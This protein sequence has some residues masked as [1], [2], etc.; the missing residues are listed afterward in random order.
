MAVMRALLGSLLAFQVAVRAEES[1]ALEQKWGWSDLDSLKDQVKESVDANS[2]SLDDVKD[3]VKKRA[4]S[5]TDGIAG[6]KQA[7]KEYADALQDSSFAKAVAAT[8]ICERLP[9]AEE[10]S[11]PEIEEEAPE[12]MGELSEDPGEDPEAC[13]AAADQV[14]AEQ[15]KSQLKEGETGGVV[16]KFMKLV[17]Q[18]SSASLC[19]GKS[20]VGDWLKEN[21]G[22]RKTDPEKY[23]EELK[24]QLQGKV[25]PVLSTYTSKLCPGSE[26]QE[27]QRLFALGSGPVATAVKRKGAAVAGLLAI[28]AV[29]SLSLSTM[30]VRRATRGEGAQELQQLMSD[31]AV[32]S[33]LEL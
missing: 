31:D 25:G 13:E 21:S 19:E 20:G 27:E 14:T 4:G 7:A 8:G 24:K 2:G 12:S 29:A 32:E 15:I 18:R 9:K 23:K 17:V 33:G 3:M 5:L 28:V 6:Y 1:V 10:R 22:L 30:V 16:D 26:E 11:A